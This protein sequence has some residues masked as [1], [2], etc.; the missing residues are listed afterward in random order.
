M[1]ASLDSDSHPS[2]A[3]SNPGRCDGLDHFNRSNVDSVRMG[4]VVVPAKAFPTRE[5][6]QSNRGGDGSPGVGICLLVE[7]S[8][9]SRAGLPILV[10]HHRDQCHAPVALHRRWSFDANGWATAVETN[11]FGGR[12]DFV[13]CRLRLA[14]GF[15][16]GVPAGAVQ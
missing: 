3:S 12:A 15:A 16:A 10:G 2:A 6:C 9:V 1:D 8:A 5:T 14:T 11:R 13:R 7:R 4:A